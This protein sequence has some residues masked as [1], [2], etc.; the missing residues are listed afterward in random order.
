MQAAQRM[1]HLFVLLVIS[2]I[3]LCQ[4]AEKIVLPLKFEHNIPVVTLHIDGRD[5]QFTLDTGA[6]DALYLDPDIESAIPE[7]T[8]TGKIVK[9][10][11]VS[12][13]VI[14]NDEI[15]IA[16]LVVD[17]MHFGQTRGRMHTPWGITA[18]GSSGPPHRSVIGLRFFENKKVLFDYSG[19]RIIIWSAE[20]G[21]P[22]DVVAWT[23]LPF[24]RAHEGVIVVMRSATRSYR[25][26]L[27][28][29]S[30]ISLV[31]SQSVDRSESTTNCNI[32]FRPGDECRQI[33]LTLS[34]GSEF[35]PFLMEMPEKFHADGIIGREFFDRYKVY[36]D[37]A[38]SSFRVQ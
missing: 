3:C 7:V 9:S 35:S 19:G 25:L 31:K 14:E 13:K 34:S 30:T 38:G 15:L 32:H 27:D 33:S 36:L 26:V 6:S 21:I 5:L 12:G 29:P 16:D 22:A 1:R 37:L 4:G 18:E 23:I 2:P 24:E 11:D 20:T 8:R 10:F 28:S 17:G